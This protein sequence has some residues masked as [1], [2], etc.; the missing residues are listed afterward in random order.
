V[1]RRGALDTHFS[2]DDIGVDRLAARGELNASVR[3]TIKEAL[4]L[5]EWSAAQKPDELPVTG[6][7][8]AECWGDAERQDISCRALTE[9]FLLSMRNATK[10]EVI[11]A[12]NVNGRPIDGGLHFLSNYG[13]GERWGSGIVNFSF[14]DDGRVSVIVASIDPPN[15]KGKA[16]DF[17]WNADRLPGG[18]SDF[19]ATHLRRCGG[20]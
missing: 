15:M 6:K 2:D 10:A 17:I 18:C 19:P 11:D 16:V 20:L 14:G 8:N 5:D 12:M 4:R 7:D 3:G 13:R 9:N 1:I